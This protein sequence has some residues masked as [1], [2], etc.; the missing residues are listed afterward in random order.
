MKC[1]KCKNIKWCPTRRGLLCM[2]FVR[3]ERVMSFAEYRR[4]KNRAKKGKEEAGAGMIGCCVGL[5]A[6]LMIICSILQAGSI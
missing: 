2:S 4:K 6:A 3:K 1:V 5:P